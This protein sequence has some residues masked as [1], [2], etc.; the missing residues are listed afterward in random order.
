MGA[1]RRMLVVAAVV[2]VATGMA[3][4][5]VPSL[6]GLVLL[7]EELTG[8]AIS[9]A[10]VTGIALIGLA[11]ACWP[12]PP[13]VGMSIY[14]AGVALYLA[15]VGLTGGRSAMLLWPAVVAHVILAGLLVLT[16]RRDRAIKA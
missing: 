4:L 16:A 7:G 5:V 10:R 13:I 12:G 8:V 15:Y 6:V 1:M 2:E 11:V 14:S 9:V 3:L